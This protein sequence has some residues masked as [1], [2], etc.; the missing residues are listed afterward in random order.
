MV[1]NDGFSKQLLAG[2][3]LCQRMCQ[4][5]DNNL[6]IQKDQPIVTDNPNL[7]WLLLVQIAQLEVYT[8]YFFAGQNNAAG[9]AL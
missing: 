8:T 9:A 7:F 5:I 2:V 3:T 1:S 6:P 4:K